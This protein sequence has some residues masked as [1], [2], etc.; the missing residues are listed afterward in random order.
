MSLTDQLTHL[1]SRQGFLWASTRLLVK[2]DPDTR[3]A[4]LLSMNI[5]HFKFINHALGQ[6]SGNLLLIRAADILRGMFRPPAVIGRLDGDMFAVLVRVANPST[7]R[8]LLTRLS[9]NIDAGNVTGLSLPLSLR[10]GFTQFD[11][12]CPIS[13]EQLLVTAHHAMH[14]QS[15]DEAN[16]FLRC[17]A[18][19]AGVTYGESSCPARH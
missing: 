13:V 19:S 12:Q 9:A 6:D 5:D 7:G 14:K 4:F 10:G 8:A 11:S 1:Y 3:W 18:V 15:A 2:R 16:P 17:E